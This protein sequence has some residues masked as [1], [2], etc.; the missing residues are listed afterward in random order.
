MNVSLCPKC[1]CM[2]KTIE[3]VCGKCR[4][5]KPHF[6]KA[7]GLEKWMCNRCT[8]FTDKKIMKKKKLPKDGRHE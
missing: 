4:H 8:T 7:P 2:T 6:S 1:H 3:N 5:H